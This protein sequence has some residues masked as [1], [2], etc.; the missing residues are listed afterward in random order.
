MQKTGGMVLWIPAARGGQKGVMEQVNCRPLEINV[1]FFV[2]QKQRLRSSHL[3][4]WGLSNR[5]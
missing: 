2:T 1:Q 5:A 4:K 3:R